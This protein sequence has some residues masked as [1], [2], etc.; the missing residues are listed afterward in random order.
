M[1]TAIKKITGFW[2]IMNFGLFLAK[3]DAFKGIFYHFLEGYKKTIDNNSKIVRNSNPVIEPVINQ[4][5]LKIKHF[6]ICVYF[7]Y[8]LSATYM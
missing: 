5:A 7:G 1:L 3:Q 4:G 2:G 6:K 8:L